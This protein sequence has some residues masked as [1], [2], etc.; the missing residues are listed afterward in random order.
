MAKD[1]NGYVQMNKFI[2]TKPMFGNWEVDTLIVFSV[3]V[4]IAILFT[5]SAITFGI[6]F[7]LGVICSKLYEKLKK[8][9]I[10]GFFLHILYML[11]VRQ[12]KKMPPSYMR[13]F[14]GA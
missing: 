1:A 14:L 3:F 11:G 2:D 12:P 13:Y 5:K 4:A 8:A 6:F 10:K 7:A 9:R